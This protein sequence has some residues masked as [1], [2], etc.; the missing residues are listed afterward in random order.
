MLVSRFSKELRRQL[1]TACYVSS[2]MTSL[3]M[4]TA[5]GITSSST[6]DKAWLRDGSLALSRPVPSVSTSPSTSTEAAS[7][8]ASLRPVSTDLTQSSESSSIVISRKEKTL[9]AI[10]PGAAPITIKTEGAQYLPEGSFS[11]TLKE[12]NPLWY[13]PREYFLKRSMVIPEEGSRER[14]KRAALGPKTIFLNNHTPIHSGPVW[15]QEIGG[16]RLSAAEMQQVFSAITVG[17][18]VEVR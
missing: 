12:E 2:L 9:T 8:R 16:I 3:G 7:P 15:M 17:T 10:N 14:F 13:A 5:C 6:S 11:V 1:R 18:R 4:L